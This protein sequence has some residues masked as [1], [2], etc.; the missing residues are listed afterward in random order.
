M[1]VNW[2][3]EQKESGNLL[4]AGVCQAVSSAHVSPVC[5]RGGH[6]IVTPQLLWIL[7]AG[8]CMVG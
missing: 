3:A 1:E 2:L 8:F 6:H 7:A 5:K 4:Y